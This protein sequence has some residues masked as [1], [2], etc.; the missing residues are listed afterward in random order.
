MKA[1]LFATGVLSVLLAIA[2]FAGAE[3]TFNGTVSDAM[4][5]K[6]HMIK[7]TSAATCTRECVKKG[8]DYALVIGDKVYALKGDKSQI[9]K[10]AGEQASVTGTVTGETIT[11]NS[12]SAPKK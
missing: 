9:D 5:G 7:N 10:F 4:C 2:A 11:V 3:Q 12:I 1:R 8:S 6:T